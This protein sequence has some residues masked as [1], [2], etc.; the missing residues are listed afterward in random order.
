MKLLLIFK[1]ALGGIALLLGLI[2]VFLPIWPTTPFVLLAL[3]CFSSTPKIRERILRISFVREYYEGYTVG[4][5]IKK[6]TVVTSLTFLWLMLIISILWTQK[7]LLAIILTCIGI[8]VTSHILWV[9]TPKEKR[10][11][12]LR[13][14]NDEQ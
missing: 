10:K 9:A 12:P 13:R 7:L 1:L 2:G 5:G 4:Q 11:L 8:G 6:K 3:W 14:T